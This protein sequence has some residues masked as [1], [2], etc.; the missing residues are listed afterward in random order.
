VLVLS[1]TK[2]VKAYSVMK[3]IS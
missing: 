2:I 3:Y 1:V